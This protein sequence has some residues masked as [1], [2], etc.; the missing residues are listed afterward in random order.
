LAA[1]NAV[2]PPIEG[3]YAT[4]E[5]EQKA[6]LVALSIRAGNVGGEALR[7][8]R[9][10]RHGRSREGM[11]DQTGMC[12]YW[13]RALL[14]WPNR[15]ID[16]AIRLSDVQKAASSDL[17]DSSNQVADVLAKT[18]PGDISLT[19]VG[20]LQ[21]MRKQLE[22]VAQAIETVRPTLAHFYETLSDEQKLR[23]AVTN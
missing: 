18:C 7:A 9:L 20:H 19:P 1:V 8:S 2:R 13:G 11:P 12:E 23:F 5:D 10:E 17:N 6:R 15:R 4:L 21:T 22:T 3:F 14:Y 16:R